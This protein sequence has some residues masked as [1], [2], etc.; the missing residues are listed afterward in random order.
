MKTTSLAQEET[1]SSIG[2]WLRISTQQGNLSAPSAG[3]EQTAALILDIDGDERND[4]IRV[5]SK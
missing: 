5:C 3:K 2:R 4:F 1:T